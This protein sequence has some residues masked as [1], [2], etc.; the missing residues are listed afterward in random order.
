MR[1]QLT[2]KQYAAIEKITVAAVYQRRKRGKL[3]FIK[4]DGFNYVIVNSDISIKKPR[5]KALSFQK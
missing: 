5:N 3:T 1:K 2:V 4:K